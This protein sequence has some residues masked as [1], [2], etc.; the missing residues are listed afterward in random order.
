M[1][2]ASFGETNYFPYKHSNKWFRTTWK[3]TIGN[4]ELL[5]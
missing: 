5:S 1:E 2:I 3:G 4:E